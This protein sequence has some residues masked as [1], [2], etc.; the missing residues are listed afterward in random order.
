M[1]KTLLAILTASTSLL[2]CAEDPKQP[3]VL[4]L[5]GQAYY[6]ENLAA[7]DSGTLYVGSLAT[8]QVVAFDDGATTPREILPAGTRGVSGV[9]VHGTELWTC[10]IDT[11]FQT[12]TEVHG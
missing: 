3:D 1:P 9:L 4:A 10:S 8:G 5:P 11:S 2:A 12:P 6:P 7:S